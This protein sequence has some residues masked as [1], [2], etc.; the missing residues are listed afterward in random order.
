MTPSDAAWEARWRA[1]V[2]TA[3]YH[4]AWGIEGAWRQNADAWGYNLSQDEVDVDV[5]GQSLKGRVFSLVG[6]VA[7]DPAT[8]PRTL[9]WP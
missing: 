9:G 3:S 6:L 4:A 2:P 1:V 8:G 5:D 7:W